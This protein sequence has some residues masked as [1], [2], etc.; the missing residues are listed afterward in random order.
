MKGLWVHYVSRATHI[1]EGLDLLGGEGTV[2]EFE[3]GD[4]A[5]EISKR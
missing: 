3:V 2:V 1:V 5:V 4:G